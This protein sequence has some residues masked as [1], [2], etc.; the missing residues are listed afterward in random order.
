MSWEGLSPGC[1]TAWNPRWNQKPRVERPVSLPGQPRSLETWGDSGTIFS[2]EWSRCRHV[3]HSLGDSTKVECAATQTPFPGGVGRWSPAALA[4]RS[5]LPAGA[6]GVHSAA[7]AR[8]PGRQ[9]WPAVPSLCFFLD[10]GL[11]WFVCSFVDLSHQ[12]VSTGHL[13]V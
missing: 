13:C 3:T 10:R 11:L 4:C 2:L 7:A 1:W 9:Q 6:A 12:Q 5:S 8:C